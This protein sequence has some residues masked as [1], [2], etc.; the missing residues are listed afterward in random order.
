MT[1]SRLAERAGLTQRM[2]SELENGTSD[3]TGEVLESLADALRCEP[4][5]LLARNPFDPKG[6]LW[7][8]WKELKPEQKMRAIQLMK[9]LLETAA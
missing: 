5:D 3:Y 1:Q 8:V 7:V 2:I 4:A 9:A 6:P